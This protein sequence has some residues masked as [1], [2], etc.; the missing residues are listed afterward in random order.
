MQGLPLVKELREAHN[1][2]EIINKMSHAY[3][4]RNFSI[5]SIKL[6][7]WAK[8]CPLIRDCQDKNMLQ[9]LEGAHQQLP[10]DPKA[11]Y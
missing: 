7:K 6:E 4:E 5:E 10:N 11:F 8:I 3:E 1:K 2:D 9:T